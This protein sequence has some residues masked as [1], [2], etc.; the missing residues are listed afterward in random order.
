MERVQV[1][2]FQG[3][4]IAYVE[5]E[6]LERVDGILGTRRQCDPGAEVRERVPGRHQRAGLGLGL[7]GPC[8][9]LDFR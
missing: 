7:P 1:V 8:R 9:S 2:G 3:V 6:D 4:G 5:I